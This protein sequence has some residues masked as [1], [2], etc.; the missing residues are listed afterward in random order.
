MKRWL[1]S[2]LVL[3]AALA[4]R[5]AYAGKSWWD[6]LEALSG[7]GPFKGKSH[8]MFEGV[9]A[10]PTDTRTSDQR[11]ELTWIGRPSVSGPPSLEDIARRPCLYFDLARLEAPARPPYPDAVAATFSEIGVSYALI[12]PIDLGMGAGVL[13]FSTPTPAGARTETRAVVT[14]I[15]FVVKP[16]FMIPSL[17]KREWPD[18]IRV[19][20]KQSLLIGGLNG[21]DF[22]ADP[23][24]FSEPSEFVRSFGLVID[25]G[26]L[27]RIATRARR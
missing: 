22:G 27:V 16:L 26:Q 8:Y 19:Y 12:R 2:A 10:G 21:G 23:A 3:V 17:Q 18:V 11:R 15:R 13:R 24:V 14:P 7:P 1:C 25:A 6:F 5:P 20:F 4:P 9:C